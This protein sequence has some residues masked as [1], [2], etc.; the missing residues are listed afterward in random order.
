MPQELAPEDK[1][2]RVRGGNG[3]EL[4]TISRLDWQGLDRLAAL[5]QRDKRVAS[6]LG[7]QEA[8]A[9]LEEDAI[10]GQGLARVGSE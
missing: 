7:V 1:L 8:W 5:R 2:D 3:E 6:W 4:G 10:H 9:G